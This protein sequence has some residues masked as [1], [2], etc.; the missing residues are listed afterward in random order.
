MLNFNYFADVRK[1]L[2]DENYVRSLEMQKNAG[3]TVLW[4]EIYMTGRYLARKQEIIDAKRKLEHMGFE[5]NVITLPVG[6]P[7]NSL[8]PEEAMDLSLPEHWAYRVNAEGEKVYFCACV[9]DTL[10][11]E[12]REVVEFCRDA[13]FKKLFFDDD[14]RMA[15]FG[16]R[17]CGCFC[18]HCVAE[19][20]AIQ[21]KRLS[22]A[23]IASAYAEKGELFEKWTEYNCSKITQFAKETAVDGIQTGFML[24]IE[25]GREQGLDVEDIKKASPGC[26]F[27]V[28]QWH[29]DDACFEG[30][31][32]HTR[33]RT[34]MK[35]HMALIDDPSVCYSETTVFPPRALTPQNLMKKIEMAIELGIH[36][37]FLMSGSW[38]MTE[39]YWK[40]LEDNMPRF[41]RLAGE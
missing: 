8:N 13:G 11:R 41:R 35:N 9:N 14:L 23:E 5:V 25:G 20:S 10:I 15:N 26:L 30:D 4:L 2:Y 37:I 38:V 39:D 36:N 21:G 34:S 17:I 40:A 28:G 32:H 19:F 31:V 6:H 22:R 29:F 16:D 3:V 33:E 7:G 1:T 27:R 18:D 24:M 12:N